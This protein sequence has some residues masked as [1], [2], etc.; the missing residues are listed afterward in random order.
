MHILYDEINGDC[1]IVRSVS[2]STDPPTC[3]TDKVCIYEEIKQGG[4]STHKA[5]VPSGAPSVKPPVV[6][7]VDH[8]LAYGVFT[9]SPNL[10]LKDGQGGVDGTQ[11]EGVYETVK[12]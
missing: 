5:V 7:G 10:G 12:Q 9:T 2:I 3:S 11:S 4:P 6:I 1:Y 8:C